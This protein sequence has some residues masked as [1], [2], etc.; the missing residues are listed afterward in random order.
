MIEFILRVLLFAAFVGWT[1][2]NRRP[3]LGF[4]DSL[5]KGA[6]GFCYGV[7][8]TLYGVATCGRKFRYKDYEL[9]SRG[10]YF[11]GQCCITAVLVII[12][13]LLFFFLVVI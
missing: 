9:C 3:L 1:Y 2:Y 4:R 5:I 12:A 6:R 11:L 13:L 8:N 10:D 7:I